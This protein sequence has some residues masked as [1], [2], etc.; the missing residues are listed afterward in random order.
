M[1]KALLF[2]RSVNSN[3]ACGND[4]SNMLNPLVFRVE[5]VYTNSVGRGN[6]RSESRYAPFSARKGEQAMTF[7]K[8]TLE[9]QRCF[10]EQLTKLLE[11]SELLSSEQFIQHGR[12]SVLEHSIAVARF[13]LQ[14]A[15]SLH[16]P[17]HTDQLIRGALLHDYFLYDWHEKDAG[18]R[19][20][21][22]T[23]PNTALRNAT[24]ILDLTP[25]EQNIISRH[26]FPLTPV[27]P[28]YVESILVC[29][30][31]KVCSTY[32]TLYLCPEL[33][34]YE[35]GERR[36][37]SCLRLLEKRRRKRAEQRQ[38]KGGQADGYHGAVKDKKDI[39]AV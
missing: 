35:Q 30:A 2:E 34:V 33:K 31:D 14:L 32:E 7:D 13:A 20:H 9:D 25:I 11:Q 1:K 19:L 24:K 18:H 15:R 3:K 4:L 6:C 38:N 21:G 5:N 39:P 26:M 8:Q 23:H 36:L 29:I 16:I 22:F 12:T 28:R 10:Q 17:V 27:P 37:D